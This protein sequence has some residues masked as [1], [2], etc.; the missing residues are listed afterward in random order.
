MRPRTAL[1]RISSP[2][3]PP[4]DGARVTVGVPV[5]NALDDVKSCLEAFANSRPDGCRIVVVDDASDQPTKDWLAAWAT[6]VPAADVVRREVNQGYTASANLIFREAQTEYVVLANS[7]TIPPPDWARRLIAVAERDGAD[8]VGPLSNAA[9]WQSV[10]EVFSDPT[11]RHLAVNALPRGWSSEDM[12]V[13][14]RSTEVA[15]PVRVP[16]LN[17]FFTLFRREVIETLGGFD[18]ELFPWGYGEE[19]DFAFRATDA[20]FHPAI[21]SNTFIF[22]AKSRSFSENQRNVLRPAAGQALRSRW[23]ARRI[24]DAIQMMREHPALAA[25]RRAVRAG[26]ASAGADDPAPRIDAGVHS[27]SFSLTTAGI[28]VQEGPVA[29]ALLILAPDEAYEGLD[30]CVLPI[31]ESEATRHRRVTSVYRCLR[32]SYEAGT[33]E[34]S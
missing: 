21:A 23:A 11:R 32:D 20:G 6:T 22:H 3:P 15:H 31:G 5:H 16:L 26:I 17:G 28:A 18:E 33:L 30:V 14:V 1:L 27:V 4:V 34:A 12:D 25:K 2:P 8:L 9:S 29:G 24:A 13:L 10:P 19:D 7:D